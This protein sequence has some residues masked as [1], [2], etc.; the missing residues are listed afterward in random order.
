MVAWVVRQLIQAGHKP[1]VLTRGY[2][3]VAG[4][5]DEAEMLARQTGAS[6][7]VNPD[8]WAGSRE[9]ARRGCDVCV[10][11]DGFQHYRL[12]R[13]LDIVLLDAAEPLGFGYC[14]PRGLLREPARALREADVIVLT[15]CD[16]AST[17]QLTRAEQVVSQF[18]PWAQLF[19]ARHAPVRWEAPDGESL[20]P[21]ALAGRPAL[22]FCG[23]AQPESFFASCRQLGVDLR[24]TVALNDHVEYTSQLWTDLQDRARSAGADILLTTAKDRVKLPAHADNLYT[25]I[26]EMQ[27]A[28]AEGLARRIVETLE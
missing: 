22:A 15:R 19:R 24:E 18:T 21:P 3:A 25:L 12:R 8:R 4:H 6:V 10:L 14:L 20:E 27:I 9:A 13:D 28:D 7:I 16:Q 2:K 11:D 1:A 17:E 5:S 26:V 23:I